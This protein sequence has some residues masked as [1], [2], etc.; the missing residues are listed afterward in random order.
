[1]ETESSIS[2]ESPKKV[3]FIETDYPKSPEIPETPKKVKRSVSLSTITSDTSSEFDLE[4]AT[5]EQKKRDEVSRGKTSHQCIKFYVFSVF[6]LP[7]NEDKRGHR[8]VQCLK[9]I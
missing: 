4:L 2:Q 1:M 7:E 5:K 3:N 9:L 8:N 6:S